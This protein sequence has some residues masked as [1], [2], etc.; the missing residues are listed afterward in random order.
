[1]N[2]FWDTNRVT[3]HGGSVCGQLRQKS[4]KDWVFDPAGLR[5]AQSM[6]ILKLCV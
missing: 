6:N 4:V 5:D 2:P 1:M 3:H